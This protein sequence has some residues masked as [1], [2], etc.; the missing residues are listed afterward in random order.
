MSTMIYSFLFLL[1]LAG[2]TKFART[3]S[4]TMR[5]TTTSP[6][7]SIPFSEP[8]MILL[9]KNRTIVINPG[10][11]E[12]LKRG[13]TKDVITSI[14]QGYVQGYVQGATINAPRPCKIL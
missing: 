7:R 1:S 5:Y 10:S 9:N 4:D 8:I 2:S 11:V 3:Y 12:F 6:A 13:R 14:M